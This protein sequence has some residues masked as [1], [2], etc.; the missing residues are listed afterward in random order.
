[1]GTPTGA[2]G[3]ID[4]V[5]GPAFAA[6]IGLLIYGTQR[7]PERRIALSGARQ[8]VMGLLSKFIGWIKSFLP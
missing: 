1:V 8:R 2:T 5:S 6:S 4:E 7:E 3:L